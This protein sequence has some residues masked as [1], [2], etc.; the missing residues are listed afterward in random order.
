MNNSRSRQL[1][2]HNL[3]AVEM[4]GYEEKRI[5]DGIREIWNSC[6]IISLR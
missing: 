2:R 1:E 6:K 4:Q 5:L 3:A